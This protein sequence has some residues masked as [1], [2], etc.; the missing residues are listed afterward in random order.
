MLKVK[1]FK[2]KGRGIVA[3]KSI[4]KGTLI[5][6]AP[7]SAFPAEE[8]KVIDKTEIFKYYF[9]N[10][11]EYKSMNNKEIKGYVVF[12]LSSL[13]NH[14]EHPN[15]KIEWR[16]DEVGLWADLIALQD[17]LA[18]EEVTVFYTN[19]DEYSLKTFI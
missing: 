18:D 5:E 16:K 15:A 9:V 14:A 17:I 6:S 3:I 4:S 7:A 1:K 8:R 2:G 13:C 10:P 19:I 11:T 12:G